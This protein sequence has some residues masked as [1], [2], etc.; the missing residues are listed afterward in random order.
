MHASS[1]EAH[2]L[3]QSVSARAKQRPHTASKGGRTK[4]TTPR[5][6]AGS[7]QWASAREKNDPVKRFASHQKHWKRKTLK[8]I[9]NN[10]HDKTRLEIR[11][12]MLRTRLLNVD[13]GKR[14]FGRPSRSVDKWA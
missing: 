8:N 11:A 3:R 10:R 4:T 1:N 9:G 2:R 7:R 14:G 6:R 13:A 5:T 12:K